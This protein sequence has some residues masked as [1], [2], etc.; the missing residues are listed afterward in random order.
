MQ[1]KERQ[2]WNGWPPSL[3]RNLAAGSGGLCQAN[4]RINN[5][6]EI[7]IT[8]IMPEIGKI[9]L[10]KSGDYYILIFGLRISIWKR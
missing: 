4:I 7:I 2:I 5:K 3:W 10:T 9:G 6:L 1:I 8:K